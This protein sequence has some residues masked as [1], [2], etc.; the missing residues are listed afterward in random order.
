MRTVWNG[1]WGRS[2][3]KSR[4]KSMSKSKMTGFFLALA[5]YSYS[6][7]TIISAWACAD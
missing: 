5:S 6:C 1:E 2:K 4:I 7:S 3:I